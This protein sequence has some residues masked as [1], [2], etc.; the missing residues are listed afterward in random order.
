M[1]R[2]SLSCLTAL[3]LI[4]FCAVAGAQ[5]TY[6][7][8]FSGPT[9]QS[10]NPGSTVSA[11]YDLTLTHAGPGPGAQGWSISLTADD[12]TITAIADGVA[13][14]STDSGALFSGGFNKTETTGPDGSR[15]ACQGKNGAVSA[16]VLSFTQPIVLPPQTTSTIGR[17]SVEATIPDTAGTATLRYANGC[18]G[19]GQP[20]DNNITQLGATVVPV[21]GTLEI[22]LTP[23]E[24]CCEA[25]QNVGFSGSRL[26]SGT[27]NDGFADGTDKCLGS[28]GEIRGAI[29]SVDVLAGVSTS[30]DS[31]GVQGWSFSIEVTGD[32]DITDATT[33]GTS[34]GLAPDGK[35]MGGF[36]KT[37]VVDPAKKQNNGRRGAVSA[38][39]LSFTMPITLD[40]PGTE[41]VLKLSVGALCEEGFDE[42]SGTIA[43]ADGLTG[44]G[45]PVNNVL[46]VAGAS[47]VVCNIASASVNAVLEGVQTQTFLRA[48]SNNDRRVDIA[49]PIWTI[50]ALFRDGPQSPCQ[51]AADSNADNLVDLADAVFTI[52]YEFLGGPEPSAP[53][54]DCGTIEVGEGALPCEASSCQ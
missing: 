17:I 45:Q 46:T 24:N 32:V 53:F 20:V 27:P 50:S 12:A 7:L 43:F 13:D 15:D 19:A 29:P 2:A 9:A 36:E 10:G 5:D 21:L 8:G 41:S 38:I 34:G 35:Q 11:D 22:A 48:D 44:S 28:G 33:E 39:V 26:A 49:D 1:K 14:K 3:S 40:V 52:E 25:V 54:P 42:C 4:A 30:G 47:G 16:I 23:E 18:K 51:A 37:E 31:A 6:T